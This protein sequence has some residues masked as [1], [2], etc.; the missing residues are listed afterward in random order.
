MTTSKLRWLA[1]LTI[2]AAT[3][4][5]LG[6]DVHGEDTCQAY[7]TSV[8]FASSPTQAA[9]M[10]IEQEKLVFVLHVSGVFEESKYT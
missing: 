5:G 1:G 3:I 7:G 2:A 10:A 6:H 9:K 4:F 8:V